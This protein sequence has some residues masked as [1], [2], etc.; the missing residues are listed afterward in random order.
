MK[1]D[2]LTLNLMLGA[3]SGISRVV[4]AGFGMGVANGAT[5]VPYLNSS[6]RI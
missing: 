2:N 4:K 3:N 5:E 1:A 6:A